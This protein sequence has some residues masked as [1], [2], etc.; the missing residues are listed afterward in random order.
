MSLL[1][2]G[3][4][5]SKGQTPVVYIDDSVFPPGTL[6]AFFEGEKFSDPACAKTLLSPYYSGSHY[7]VPAGS[8]LWNMLPPDPN[9]NISSVTLEYSGSGSVETYKVDLCGVTTTGIVP[10]TF[11]GGTTVNLQLQVTTGPGAS[12]LVHLL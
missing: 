10:V 4:F 2:T 9:T 8:V 3:A 6:Q 7:S 11:S 1:L 12:I 5:V